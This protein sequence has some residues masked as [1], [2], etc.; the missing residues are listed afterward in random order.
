MDLLK[1]RYSETCTSKE[2]ERDGG[3]RSTTP[4]TEV[5]DCSTLTTAQRVDVSVESLQK[6]SF[7]D[8]YQ[9][10]SECT[11]DLCKLPGNAPL[12]RRDD[13]QWTP[14]PCAITKAD[15]SAGINDCSM[16]PFLKQKK[17]C[18]SQL[19]VSISKKPNTRWR[20]RIA[21]K[22][23]VCTSENEQK[24]NQDPDLLSSRLAKPVVIERTRKRKHD[25]T[26]DLE[27]LQ[28][29]KRCMRSQSMSKKSAETMDLVGVCA[30]DCNSLLLSSDE[31]EDECDEKMVKCNEI[32]RNEGPMDYRKNQRNVITKRLES[33][34][35][36]HTMKPTLNI[37]T[38][39]REVSV[40]IE[41]LQLTSPSVR[42]ETNIVN[43]VERFSFHPISGH[44]DTG[45]DVSQDVG[46][47]SGVKNRNV[48]VNLEPVNMEISTDVSSVEGSQSRLSRV[49]WL[50]HKHYDDSVDD[51]CTTEYSDVLSKF[52]LLSSPE[53]SDLE[54][55]G[56]PVP[57]SPTPDEQLLSLASPDAEADAI[58][59]EKL[60][61]CVCGPS[62]ESA[63]ENPSKYN[64]PTTA[65]KGLHST[66]KQMSQNS[67]TKGI[68]LQRDN[69]LSDKS[70]SETESRSV[71]LFSEFS[72]KSVNS[73]HSDDGGCFIQGSAENRKESDGKREKT[74][75]ILTTKQ[76]TVDE[77]GCPSNLKVSHSNVFP[78]LKVEKGDCL[79]VIRPL[80]D[81]PLRN[82]VASD[83]LLDS[84]PL[85][86]K[87]GDV[88]YSNPKDLPPRLRLDFS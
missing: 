23:A 31:Q 6:H 73:A 39:I 48:A 59:E 30:I 63:E 66:R 71:D 54:S 43:G 17:S 68:V 21:S 85:K 29:E 36:L 26:E 72:F 18:C 81:A 61:R 64:S 2:L 35:G 83:M 75:W 22:N 57:M 10:I 7:S 60:R 19:L 82:Q 88:F 74:D 4:S 3:R 77:K 45:V 55:M 32:L 84:F 9:P 15:Q 41:N 62:S 1:T 53:S 25:E 65:V 47:N 51:D 69:S 49:N 79:V 80:I 37:F 33:A 8:C 11:V 50:Q 42:L 5:K 67:A 56:S 12:C 38:D 78:R 87:P 58:E 52:A 24:Q 76:M 46:H 70:T 86:K 13:M 14:V 34:S 44:K 16:V 27:K 20:K 28:S 40:T